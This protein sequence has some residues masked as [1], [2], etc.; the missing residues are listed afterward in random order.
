MS[1]WALGEP[2]YA[3]AVNCPRSSLASRRRRTVS[4]EGPSDGLVFVIVRTLGPG[5]CGRAGSL[6]RSPPALRRGSADA[7]ARFC[8]FKA[9]HAT[10]LPIAQV[11][12]VARADSLPP[13]EHA[14]EGSLPTC[15]TCCDPPIGV[16]ESGRGHPAGGV[17]T[18]DPL[19]SGMDDPTCVTV[20]M[21]AR[22][23]GL[24]TGAIR[25]RVRRRSCD[26]ERIGSVCRIGRSFVRVLTTEEVRRVT[27]P[28]RRRRVRCR[29][30]T[31]WVR[32]V[33]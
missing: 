10:P 17:A 29:L 31:A 6:A 20:P 2:R 16:Q 21:L 24:G 23:L 14:R 18:N 26:G 19:R 15:N 33:E 9:T 22:R 13:S 8:R 25:E 28:L 12:Y 5:R 32:G 7:P 30:A 27:A 4:G 1:E 11:Q 3:R